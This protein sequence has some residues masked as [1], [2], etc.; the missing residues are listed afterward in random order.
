MTDTSLPA[1]LT[2]IDRAHTALVGTLAGAGAFAALT[3]RQGEVLPDALTDDGDTKRWLNVLIAPGPVQI[4]A[5]LI[6]LGE[7]FAEVD[8]VQVF[9]IEWL[10]QRENTAARTRAF[11]EGL[12]AISEALRG[13][14]RLSGVAC[15]LVIGPP[16]RET[17]A[18]PFWPNTQS[19]V[20]PV[21][22]QLR[23]P[24]PIR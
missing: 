5:E 13:N 12:I 11:Q 1:D 2:L 14:R 20:I 21:R 23:G 16:N 6:G 3:V 10:V 9:N 8:Y 4:L 17:N 15:G 7:D 18:L 24:D 22:V 19:A